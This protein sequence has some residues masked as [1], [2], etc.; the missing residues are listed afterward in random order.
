[1]KSR[2]LE[3]VENRLIA[4]CMGASEAH[5]RLVQAGYRAE[6]DAL[7]R[8]MQEFTDACRDVRRRVV[9]RE[10][11]ERR[12]PPWIDDPTPPRRA[13]RRRVPR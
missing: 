2:D 6:A 1:M 7:M 5:E 13:Y 4:P 10:R 3:Y 9:E 12:E 8:A 11:D